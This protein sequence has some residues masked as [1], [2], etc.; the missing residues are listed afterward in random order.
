ML[1]RRT[2][3]SVV[4]SR[5]ASCDSV[6]RCDKATVNDLLE[7]DLPT[8]KL[9]IVAYKLTKGLEQV[10]LNEKDKAEKDVLKEQVASP[11]PVDS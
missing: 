7:A 6:V 11:F 2:S 10:I 5:G 8:N 3:L 4:G 1:L 9:Q